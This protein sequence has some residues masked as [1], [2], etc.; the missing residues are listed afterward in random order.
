MVY[1]TISDSSTVTCL[2]IDNGY[3]SIVGP[4]YNLPV[5]EAYGIT[6]GYAYHNSTMSGVPIK[7]FDALPYDFAT[8]FFVLLIGVLCINAISLRR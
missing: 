5:K 4:V 2:T 1:L 3:A 8:L 6:H 7:T